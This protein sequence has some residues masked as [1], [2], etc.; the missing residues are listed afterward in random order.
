MKVVEQH[1]YCAMPTLTVS[2]F[3]NF[4]ASKEDIIGF[5]D[6]FMIL[7][8]YIRRD[9]GSCWISLM[10]VWPFRLPEIPWMFMKNIFNKVW[11]RYW[12]NFMVRVKETCFTHW[13]IS[14]S[15]KSLFN[16]FIYDSFLPEKFLHIFARIYLW[17]RYINQTFSANKLWKKLF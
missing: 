16:I 14:I 17:K 10:I 2:F 3:P 11:W 7:A 8:V 1:L 6:G 13:N 4:K 12:R 15:I 5:Y 9:F